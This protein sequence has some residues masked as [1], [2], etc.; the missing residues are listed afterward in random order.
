MNWSRTTNTLNPDFLKT[1]IIEPITQSIR[2]SDIFARL[3]EEKFA[4][5][6][7]D[8]PDLDHVPILIQKIHTA[9]YSP[10]LGNGVREKII[11]IGVS[12]YPL[13]GQDVST[14]L[15]RAISNLD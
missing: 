7:E 14:L 4:I 11:N 6:L 10:D 9:I 3:T 12:T 1:E 2:E 8:V 15:N 13:D 5:I